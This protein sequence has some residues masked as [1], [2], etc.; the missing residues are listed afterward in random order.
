MLEFTRT[1]RTRILAIL[2]IGLMGLF[3]VRLFYLQIIQHEH[4]MLLANSEQLRQ[5]KLPAVRGEIYA[6]D[7]DKPTRLVL[8]QTVYT[9]WADPKVVEDA[10]KVSDVLQR[11]IQP[12][13][14]GN[15]RELLDK[16]DTR[17]QILAK[18]VTYK[19]AQAIKKEQ[20]YGI[21]FERGEK[22]VYPEG[23]LA[24]QIV[25]FVNNDGEGQYGVEG[26]LDSELKGTDGMLKTVADVRDVPLTIGKENV[27]IPAENGK[28][29]VL[30]ID[31]NVQAKAEQLIA[32]HTK[33]LG[34]TYGS[35]LVMDPKTGRV[36][37]MANVPTY[38][39]S[40]LRTITDIAN[41]NNRIV[42]RPYEPASV[43]KTVTMA[44]GIDKGVMTP[45]SRYVN[46]NFITI[47]DATITNVSKNF[48]G[49]ITMQTV[50]DASLNTGTVT[51]AEWLGGGS[52]NRQARDTM[53]TYFHDKLGLGERTGI[54]LAGEAK[55]I[56]V[57]PTEVEGNAVRYANMTFGQGLDVTPLQVATAF[58]AIVNGG[59]HVKPTV[60][61][62]SMDA[63]GNYQP[64]PERTGERVL[65]ESTSTTMREMLYKAR[66]RWDGGSDPKGYAIGGKTG[67]AQTIENGKYVF[68]QT[69][70]TYLGLGGEKGELPEYVIL[71]TFAGP[72]RTYGG[73]D[74]LPAFTDMSNWMV[75]YLK[76]EPKG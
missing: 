46:T 38:D 35:L 64:A 45:N 43:I 25:G 27:N 40:D 12:K 57:P 54:E 11:V 1:N 66:G 18:D 56:V 13:L 24:S 52:I 75:S 9:L 49:T 29:I 15:Y 34:A 4:Y 73:F 69:E 61:A 71:T 68:S 22:R 42:T 74:A 7:G 5:W 62:G 76:L 72:N 50:L 6:L 39:P 67:T 37:A 21:G 14:R 32:K 31:R 10:T 17:Y 70:G 59:V 8:N 51:M 44:T 48:T 20:L 36:L 30:T 33:R 16:K 23:S 2:T 47:D 41:V 55:G 3:V 63:D 26:K 65:K 19:E 60:I 28:N 58:S 53:Y